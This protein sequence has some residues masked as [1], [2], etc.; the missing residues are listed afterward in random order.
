[1]VDPGSV[2]EGTLVKVQISHAGVMILQETYFV[3][4]PGDL[5]RA[6]ASARAHAQTRRSDIPAVE[7]LARVDPETRARPGMTGFGIGTDMDAARPA[8]S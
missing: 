3:S 6:T 2:G 5:R 1:M 7:L 4:R 8:A